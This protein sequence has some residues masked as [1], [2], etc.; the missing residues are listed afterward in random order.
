MKLYKEGSL[1]FKHCSCD[2]CRRQEELFISRNS[3]M[4]YSM[5]RC[6]FASTCCL[7]F[8]LYRVVL[9][10]VNCFHLNTDIGIMILGGF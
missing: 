4:T 1:T 5:S 10:C 3:P 9:L 7:L 6:K 8:E 2:V